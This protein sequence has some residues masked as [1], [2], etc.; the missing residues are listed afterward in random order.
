MPASIRRRPRRA[1][2]RLP[3]CTVCAWRRC[4]AACM[5]K[6]VSIR[7]THFQIGVG[8]VGVALVAAIASVRFCG[9]VSLPPKPPP[10]AIPH[11]TSSEL[12]T[13]SSASPVVYRDF[14][15]RDAAAAGVRTPTLEELSRK[16]PYRIDDARHVLEVGEPAIDLAGVQLRAIHL[17]DALALEVANATGSDIAYAVASAPI[18]AT[19]CNAASALAFNAM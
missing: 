6:S 19:G 1:S 10:P 11:G 7:D 16:L 12:L 17:D 15:A 13:R 3:R 18:P 5:V 9:G 8:V 2:Q 14:I 4:D